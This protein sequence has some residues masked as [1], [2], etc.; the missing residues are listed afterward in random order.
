MVDIK[1]WDDLPD[2][3]D[4]PQSQATAKATECFRKLGTERRR[5]HHAVSFVSNDFLSGTL[6]TFDAGTGGARV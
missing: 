1:P 3:R 5:M 6:Y 4:A 2:L